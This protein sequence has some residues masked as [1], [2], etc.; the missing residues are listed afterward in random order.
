MFT[1]TFE[2]H[3]QIIYPRNI[4]AHVNIH[5]CIIPTYHLDIVLRVSFDNLLQ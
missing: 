4:F 3:Q 5:V 2:Y 1:H